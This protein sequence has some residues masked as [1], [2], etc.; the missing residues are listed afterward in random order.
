MHYTL[1]SFLQ[2]FDNKDICIFGTSTYGRYLLD[3][4]HEQGCKVNCFISNTKSRRGTRYFGKEVKM[5]HDV[6]LSSW[7]LIAIVDASAKT[8]V[9]RQVLNAGVDPEHIVIPLQ[10]GGPF[11]SP[12]IDDIP[13]FANI[14][15]QLELDNIKKNRDYF[16]E[17]F[18]C[19]GL[20]NL[21]VYG[22]ED[23]NRTVEELI[24]GTRLTANII[25]DFGKVP[26]DSDVVIITD[27]ENYWDLEERCMEKSELPVV[28]FWSVRK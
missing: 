1:D 5:L 21:A 3:R 4:L 2:A 19:N 27:R 22:K 14:I 8:E 13:E 16:C 28:N 24:L 7:F 26:L 6:D 25:H 11:S 9:M 23:I 18:L 15:R 20:T 10:L 12:G 17:Y